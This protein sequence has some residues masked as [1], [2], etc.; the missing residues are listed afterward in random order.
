MLITSLIFFL[1]LTSQY[2]PPNNVIYFRC[3]WTWN[4][5][6]HIGCVA[7]WFCI[8]FWVC[9]FSN[10]ILLFE[11]TDIY[12]FAVRVV[13]CSGYCEQFCRERC[14][15]CTLVC[16]SVGRLSG[17]DCCVTG[18]AVLCFCDHC[19]FSRAVASVCT[20]S[21]PCFLFPSWSCQ[22]LKF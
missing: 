16:V 17:E 7:M 12:L 18:C 4:I 11:Y 21:L 8:Q 19:Q 10:S 14:C 3:F 22:I 2:L 20:L 6:S 15:V 13:R 9:S 5:W 1:V